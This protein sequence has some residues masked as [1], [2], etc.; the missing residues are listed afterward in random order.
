M[1]GT[2]KKTY[3]LVDESR[4]STLR[5]SAA[6]R[7]IDSVPSLD[8]VLCAIHLDISGGSSIRGTQG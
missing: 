2:M 6:A 5:S 8:S 7:L 4:L 3:I 1:D